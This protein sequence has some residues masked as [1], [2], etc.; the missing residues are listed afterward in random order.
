LPLIEATEYAPDVTILLAG[1]GPQ[2]AAVESKLSDHPRVRYLG[3][4]PQNQVP[5]YTNLADV[6]YYGINA[7][8]GNAPY[9]CPNT[10]FNALTAGKPLLTTNV[11]EIAHIVREE[12]CGVV[13]EQAT[14]AHLAQAITQLRDPALYKSLAANARR[15]AQTKYN[16]AVAQAVLLDT[17]QQLVTRGSP[18]SS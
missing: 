6:V 4:V 17:Y 1:D 7:S 9:S 10:L 18:S 2:R 13:V 12:Q 14:P 3:Q 11:G 5:E 15:A 16:W 8:D